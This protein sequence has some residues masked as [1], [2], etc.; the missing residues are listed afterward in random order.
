[1][2][3]PVLAACAAALLMSACAS[4]QGPTASPAAP[5]RYSAA[6][7]R[8]HEFAVRRCA[9]CHTV[10][11]DD[12]GASEGPSFRSLSVRYNPLSLERRFTEVSSH[13]ADRMPPVGFTQ[14]EAED[15]VAYLAT[16][17]RN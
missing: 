1:M 16:L 10:G 5:M 4:T 6:E 14:S 12:G 2:F 7:A 3:R 13:G 8:G 11:L 9:G 17:T 15:L